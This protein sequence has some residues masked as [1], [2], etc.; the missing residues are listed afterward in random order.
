VWGHG[1][2]LRYFDNYSEGFWMK[3]WRCP[4]CGAV[5]TCRPD[6]HWRRFWTSIAAIVLALAG[7]LGSEPNQPPTSRQNRQYWRRG[8]RIQSLVLG[9]PGST[10]RE[11]MDEGIIAATHSLTDRAIR[12]W[13]QPPHPRLA[14]TGPP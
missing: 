8:Y 9:L 14:A 7:I 1:Y 10:V 5:H 12:H 4:D 11:L 3:R 2:V 6:T 13:P